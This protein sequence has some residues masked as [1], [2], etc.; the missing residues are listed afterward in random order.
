MGIAHEIQGSY[1][2]PGTGTLLILHAEGLCQSAKQHMLRSLLKGW[3]GV[4]E[5]GCWLEGAWPV[6]GP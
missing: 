1:V 2:A 4:T 5:V 3:L 6:N